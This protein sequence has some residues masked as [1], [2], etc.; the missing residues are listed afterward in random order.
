MRCG[1]RSD[2]LECLYFRGFVNCIFTTFHYVI[3]AEVWHNNLFL[4]IIYTFLSY[5]V[6]RESTTFIGR[7]KQVRSFAS[8]KPR[9]SRRFVLSINVNLNVILEILDQRNNQYPLFQ[10]YS[11][12]CSM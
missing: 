6:L 9:K 11:I 2:S 7:D 8:F 5:L 1:I 3:H 10:N 4:L 12:S